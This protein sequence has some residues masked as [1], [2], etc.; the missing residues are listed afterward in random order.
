MKKKELVEFLETLEWTDIPVRMNQK[1]LAAV[2]LGCPVCKQMKAD[3]HVE[4]CK[5]KKVL[6]R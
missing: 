2:V 1:G 3:G 4:D 5:M 6:G